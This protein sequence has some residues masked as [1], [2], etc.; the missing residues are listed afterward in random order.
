VNRQE[1]SRR[2]AESGVALIQAI[3]FV[4]LLTTVVMVMSGVLTARAHAARMRIERV[5]AFYAAEAGAA[6]ALAGIRGGSVDSSPLA[7]S[8][9]SARYEVTFERGDDGGVI[10]MVATGSC[11]DRSRVLSYELPADAFD[12]SSARA[13]LDTGSGN[14]PDGL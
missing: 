4:G 13:A 1:G 8:V 14:D 5:Q 10:V 3:I 12:R 11:G 7:G 9:G 2:L 6:V